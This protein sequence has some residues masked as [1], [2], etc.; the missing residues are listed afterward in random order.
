MEDFKDGEGLRGCQQRAVDLV[1]DG[2]QLAGR[3]EAGDEQGGAHGACC[4][5][6]EAGEVEEGE[7]EASGG[8]EGRGFFGGHF[9]GGWWC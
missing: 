3:G 4:P 6:E 9:A 2:G 8:G 7:V 5:E 1:E